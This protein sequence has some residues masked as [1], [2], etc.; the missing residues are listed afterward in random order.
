MISS[1]LSSTSSGPNTLGSVEIKMILYDEVSTIMGY[2]Y[3]LLSNLYHVTNRGGDIWL[4]LKGVSEE[5]KKF[6]LV[7]L[8]VMAEPS[9]M[10]KQGDAVIIKKDPNRLWSS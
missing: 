8:S 3:V 1:P 10:R 5:R 7:Y 6:P 2:H 9:N 4:C